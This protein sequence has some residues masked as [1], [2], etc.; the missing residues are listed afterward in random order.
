[1]SFF[2]LSDIFE[3]YICRDEREEEESHSEIR[4]VSREREMKGTCETG[5][6]MYVRSRLAA[7]V[8]LLIYAYGN[9]ATT[10]ASLSPPPRRCGQSFRLQGPTSLQ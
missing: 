2:I 1:M 8:R 9:L 5:Y 4:K 6:L 3:L 10:L 7:S